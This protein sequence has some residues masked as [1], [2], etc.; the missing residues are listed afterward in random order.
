MFFQGCFVD[1]GLGGECDRS[2]GGMRWEDRGSVNAGEGK[3]HLS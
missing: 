3:K 2:I 1:N